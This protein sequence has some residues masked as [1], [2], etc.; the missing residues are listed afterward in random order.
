[1]HQMKLALVGCQTLQHT[2]GHHH[3]QYRIV[4]SL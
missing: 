1:M 2:Y 3:L 4:P